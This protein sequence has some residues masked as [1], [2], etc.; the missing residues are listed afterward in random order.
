MKLFALALLFAT[1]ATAQTTA[2]KPDPHAGHTHNLGAAST[3]LT[4]INDGKVKTFTLAE[5]KA[6]P[7]VDI[8]V[9]DG[10]TKKDM[11]WSGPLV[12]DVLAACGI[13]F[14]HETEH[15]LV[16]RYAV[17]YGT[18]GYAVVFS[19]AELYGVFH[20]GKTIVALQRDG[21]PLP[22]T[23]GQFTL[24][25]SADLMTARR[26]SNFASLEVRSATDATP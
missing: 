13:E 26:V 17:A 7:Q 1:A 22:A 9:K 6:L 24:F 2:A 18:D 3:T 16:H 25:D 4:V 19:I 11:T 20:T 21:A 8:T 14:N 23:I 15:R 12:S 5:L 10:R